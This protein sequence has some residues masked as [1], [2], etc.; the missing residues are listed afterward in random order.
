MSPDKQDL[1]EGP[2]GDTQDEE[3]AVEHQVG[4]EAPAALRTDLGLNLALDEPGE[5]VGLG[6][7]DG[8][9]PL[10][11]GGV[12]LEPLDKLPGGVC[13]LLEFS[14]DGGH[15]PH[16]LSQ[17][18]GELFSALFHTDL[19]H[20]DGLSLCLPARASR[21]PDGQGHGADAAGQREHGHGG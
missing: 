4:A 16:R 10:V 8:G 19:R 9:E 12:L 3:Q 18:A 7:V 6:L 14:R 2:G 13:F 11:G 20:F 1:D 15:G 17:I 5:G 21:L